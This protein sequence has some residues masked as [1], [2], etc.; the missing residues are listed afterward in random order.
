VTALTSPDTPILPVA[1]PSTLF[2]GPLAVVTA[3]LSTTEN[4]FSMMAG[5]GLDY[6]LSK[7]FSVRPVEVD[8]VLTRFPSL[9]TGFRD[10]QHSIAA[11]AGIIFTFGAL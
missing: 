3:R 10:N 6:R 8:Y 4:A 2:P 1:N 5:G 7:H 11:S 9:S